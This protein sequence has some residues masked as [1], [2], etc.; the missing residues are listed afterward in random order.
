M[1]HVAAFSDE[2]SGGHEFDDEHLPS[3]SR[4]AATS[5]RSLGRDGEGKQRSVSSGTQTDNP[6]DHESGTAGWVVDSDHQDE[7]TQVRKLA[8]PLVVDVPGGP[9]G[10]D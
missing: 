5:G 7:V 3:R 2:S 1:Q 8:V 9:S 10:T 6:E 4:I